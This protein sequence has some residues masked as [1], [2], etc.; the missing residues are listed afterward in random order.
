MNEG[1]QVEAET[2]LEEL[3]SELVSRRREAEAKDMELDRLRSEISQIKAE[4]EAEATHLRKL[5]EEAETMAELERFRAMEHLRQEHQRALLREQAQVD[6]ERERSGE[7]LRTLTDLF[8]AEKADLAKKV[9][10]LSQMVK[11]LITARGAG[12]VVS[13]TGDVATTS[14]IGSRGHTKSWGKG[15][16]GL[17]TECY[18]SQ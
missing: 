5:M 3:R 12:G 15:Q 9:E 7:Q 14:I 13:A 17:L 8:A 6:L 2:G 10:E 4:A 11:A 1:T 18:E 16:P